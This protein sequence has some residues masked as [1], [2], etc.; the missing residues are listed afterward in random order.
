MGAH[1]GESADTIFRRKMVDCELFGRT[2]WVVKSSKARPEQVR[3]LCASRP[4]YVIFVEPADAGRGTPNHSG[5]SPRHEY[6]PDRINWSLASRVYRASHGIE[7]MA[8]ATALVFD[9]L[10]TDVD[11]TI[12]LWEYADRSDVSRPLRFA[13]GLS[14]HCA[15]RRDTFG[16][17]RSHEIPRTA[18]RCCW[19]SREAILRLAAI[20]SA[21]LFVSQSAV[22]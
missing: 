14:T 11:G 7:W 19:S 22:G 13:L 4:G 5:G 8:H 12:H 6:S 17:P 15:V 2:F 18:S 16:A 1:A 20:G 9:L 3:G 21:A 10:L